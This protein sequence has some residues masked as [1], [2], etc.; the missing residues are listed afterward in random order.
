MINKSTNINVIK[1]N[2]ILINEIIME[3]TENLKSIEQIALQYSMTIYQV[4]KVLIDNNIVLR[5]KNNR[6][7]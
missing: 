4:R 6:I 5:T 1:D 2:I 7:I 3:Y